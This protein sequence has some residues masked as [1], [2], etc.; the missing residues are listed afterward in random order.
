MIDSTGHAIHDSAVT[1]GF[2]DT[3]QTAKEI[4]AFDYRRG[5]ELQRE[6]IMN[7]IASVIDSGCLIL[8]PNVRAFEQ[9]FSQF[10]GSSHAVGISSGTD[11]LI[12]AMLALDVG[13]GNEVITVANGPV[14]TATAIRSVGAIP[15]FV[16]VDPVTLQ[17]DVNELKLAISSSTRCVIPLHLYGIPAPTIEIARIC[18]DNELSLI[19]DCAQAHGTKILER[20]VGTAGRIGCFSFYPTKNLGAFG[21]AGMC[22]TNDPELDVRLRELRQYGFRGKERIAHDHGIN[23]RLDELHAACL[24][25][26]LRHLD[27]ALARRKEIAGQYLGQLQ[28]LPVGLP[29]VPLFGDSSWHQFVVRVQERT[30]WIKF[31]EEQ[32]VQVGVHYEWPVHRM[33]GFLKTSRACGRLSST[34][35]AC[36]EVMSL[37]IF[38][39]LRSDEIA[40]VVQAIRR[41]V[42]SGLR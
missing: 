7:A 15:V 23:G 14:P 20:H 30:R 11:A 24:R 21:D 36:V 29:A 18:Q 25:V 17:M 40:R 8:G 26:R 28:G 9:E 5:W 6:E 22:V 31:L 4:P 35:N 1:T 41:G 10:V 39:E 16:D 33:P 2:P 42:N 32:H 3:R 27:E 19:E 37:P 12:A 38:P 13:P 34:L